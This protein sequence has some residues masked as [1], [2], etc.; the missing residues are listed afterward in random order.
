VTLLEIAP[1]FACFDPYH[2]K[3]LS[4]AI[5]VSDFQ[6]SPQR[7]IEQLVTFTGHKSSQNDCIPR[8]LQHIPYIYICSLQKVA[9]DQWTGI[10]KD[11]NAACAGV[12]GSAVRAAEAAAAK[13]KEACEKKQKR[14]SHPF[15]LHLFQGKGRLHD[16]KLHTVV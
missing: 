16:Q 5:L 8:N 11:C 9:L 6:K 1:K 13:E 4:T 7:G 3:Y 15:S 10:P 14:G 12:T 2:G